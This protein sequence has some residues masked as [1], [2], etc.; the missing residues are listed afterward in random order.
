MSDDDQHVLF[1]GFAAFRDDGS[2]RF[3]R[4][5]LPAFGTPPKTAAAI[6]VRLSRVVFDVAR[7]AA[8]R[9]LQV[10]S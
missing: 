4:S 7:E 10:G 8:R 2:S 3:Y 6:T 5:L 1:P 9:P